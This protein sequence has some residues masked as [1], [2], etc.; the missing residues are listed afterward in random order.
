[1]KTVILARISSNDSQQ[2]YSLELIKEKLREYSRRHNFQIISEFECIEDSDLGESTTLLEIIDIIKSQ[3]DIVY[4]L[5]Y[6]WNTY[7]NKMYIGQ[8]LQELIANKK[9][10]FKSYCHP[11][12]KEP[13]N[14]NIK[15]WRYINLAKFVDLIKTRSLFFTR[16]DF[17][18]EMDKHEG[19]LL[20]KFSH[21]LNTMLS[22]KIISLPDNFPIPLEAHLLLQTQMDEYNEQ[23]EIKQIFIN[24][25]HMAEFENFAM[26][27]IYSDLFGVCIESTY[28]RLCDSFI[29]DK[30][31]FYNEKNKIYIGEVIYIDRNRSVIPQN[32]AFWAYMHKAIEF[33]YEHELRCI[34]SDMGSHNQGI[35]IKVDIDI[36]IQK[37]RISPF[38]PQWF[39]ST[40]EDL[41][42]K[43]RVAPQKVHQSNLI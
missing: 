18:R 30:W 19:R 38:A 20:T 27:K 23:T 35:K 40:I 10:E 29:D 43:Y 16:A 9:V 22:E 28:Q 32:N 15:I 12:F 21:Q 11:C 31:E 2:E 25:W 39:K 26:W 24:C 34:V 13:V 8:Q 7:N 1:V 37:I 36:L 42:E 4:I 5:T 6:H 17:L 14:N 33:L 3:E 41:C